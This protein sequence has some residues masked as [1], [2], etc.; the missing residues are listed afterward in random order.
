MV[1]QHIFSISNLFDISWVKRGETVNFTY[2]KNIFLRFWWVL[3]KWFLI[4]RNKI[5]SVLEIGR[6]NYHWFSYITVSSTL[7][8]PL[9]NC[10]YTNPIVHYATLIP[11][12]A[13]YCA[14]ENQFFSP[15]AN[16]KNRDK[17]S[18][19]PPL[20]VH[21]LS[22]DSRP[23]DC[24]HIDKFLLFRFLFNIYLSAFFGISP[25]I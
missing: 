20:N 17:T 21:V 9:Q 8:F 25:I 24:L 16:S 1:Y 19:T 6:Q 4:K 13:S 10:F 5:Y 14:C 11:V 15:L 3:S 22:Q 7:L 2:G 18:V 12:V 23:L